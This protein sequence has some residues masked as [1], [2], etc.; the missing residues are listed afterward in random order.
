MSVVDSA[1][2]TFIPILSRTCSSLLEPTRMPSTPPPSISPSP[3]VV[4]ASMSPTSIASPVRQCPLFHR[5]RNT[6]H[7]RWALLMVSRLIRLLTRRLPLQHRHNPPPPTTTLIIIITITQRHQSH[8]KH[9]D[10][11]HNQFKG[12]RSFRQQ[13]QLQQRQQRQQQR[14]LLNLVL[15]DCHQCRFCLPIQKP[16]RCSRLD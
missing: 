6:S 9:C 4:R 8:L 3:R 11:L 2:I 14:A 1:S 13:Q 7:A 15:V 12:D 10:C 5:A 16:L